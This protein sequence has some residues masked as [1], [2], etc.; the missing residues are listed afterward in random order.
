MNY[1]PKNI[2]NIAILGHQ[3][4]GKTTLTE[5]LAYK[6]GLIDKQGSIEAKNTISDYLDEEKKRLSSIQT[7]IVPIEK[8]GYKLNLLDLPGNDDFV[9]EILGV[10]RLIKG[11]V[12]VIDASKGVQNGTVKHFNMLKKRGVPIF[13]F[14]NKMDKEN[15]NFDELFEEICA[16][17]GGKKCIPFSYPIGRKENF[18][19]FVN[20]V[21]LK[22]QKYNGVTCEDDVIYEDKRA[23]I[24]ELH[25]TLCE[26]VATT[27]DSLLEKFFSG[28]TLTKEEIKTG[29]RTGVLE[30]DLYPVLVG[31]ASKDIGILTLLNMLIDY[32]PSPADLKPYQAI[33][34]KGNEIDIKTDVNEPTT[35]YVFKN[36]YSTYQGLT[37]IFK[38]NSGSVK[39][40]D[41][42]YCPNINETVRI[43]SL[44]SVCGNKFTPVEEVSA[45][46]IG[47]FNKLDMIRLGYTLCEQG[48][49]LKYKPV[50]Y[51]TPTYFLGIIP[52]SK[53]DSDKL[54]PAVE[55]LQYEDPTIYLERNETTGQILI[56]GTTSSH[57]NYVLDCLRSD[58]KLNFKTEAKKISYRETITA[59]AEAEGRYIKQSGGSGFYGVVNMRFEP[60]DHTYFTSSV[61]G[62][63]IS[64]GYFPAIEKGFLEAMQ[65]GSLVQA[66]V[67]N[68]HADVYDGKEHR[69]DSNELAFK[70]AAIQAF[71]E[72]YMKCEPVLLEPYNKIVINVPQEF[73]GSVLS[74]L[75]KRRAKISSTE[76]DQDGSFN[77]AASIPEAEILEYANDLKS[78]TRGTGFFNMSFDT[79]NKVPKELAE[80]IIQAHKQ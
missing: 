34:E 12:L 69:V 32:F 53:N 60:A 64:S 65:H 62:G 50:K 37:S 66:P 26:A 28:E 55:K 57:L 77:I 54:F 18:D 45:G 68:V 23:K 76:E 9:Y 3:S 40:G 72:A 20:V 1:A 2:R 80:K 44:F 22:A 36:T 59:S 41:T 49:K 7:S 15:V 79:Y 10:T 52:A 56:G 25:N 4:S 61:T 70:N 17:L 21:E 31:S 29:L 48:K 71:R 24:F 58:Y 63:H 11:A 46:D 13:I 38:V 39:L 16:K 30:A 78:L 74:D 33:D 73:I 75:S 27:D 5:A 67:L 47:A 42:L 43:T 35:L 6:A 51:P 19:G 14:V 8:D